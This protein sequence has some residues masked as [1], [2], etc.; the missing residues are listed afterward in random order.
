M[1][2]KEVDKILKKYEKKLAD[3][4]GEGYIEDFENDVVNKEYELFRS[5]ILEQKITNYER[6]C[7]TAEGFLKVKPSDKDYEKIRKSIDAAHLNVTPESAASLGAM[8]GILLIILG[9]VVGAL[10][11]VFGN[12][13]LFLPIVLI[14]AGAIVIKPLSNM[15][16]YLA[17]KWRLEA[18][19]QMVLCVL[20]V[21]MYMR[22]TSNLEHAIRFAAQHV[23]PPLSLDL[24]KVFWDIETERF[25]SIKESLD[26]YLESWRDHNLEFVQSFNLIEGSLYEPNN[27]RRISLLE[28]ALE[29]MLEG[30]YNKMLHYAH[31]LKGPITLLYMLG[32]ILPILGLVIFPLIGSFMGGLV[33]WYHLAMLYNLFL[34]LILIFLGS[35]LLAKRPTGYGESEILRSHP[36][37]KIYEQWM[38]NDK[39]VP[40]SPKVASIFVAIIIGIFGLLPLLVPIISPGYDFEVPGLGKMFD[41]KDFGGGPYGV[42]ALLLGMLTPLGIAA[43]VSMYYGIK[44]KRLIKV[45]KKVDNLEDEF[46][47]AIF[48]L[49]NRIA[50]GI[51]SEMAFGDVAKAM[52]GTPTGNFFSTV[53][54]NIRK[55][56]YGMKKAVFDN[57]VGAILLFPSNL[58]QTTMK[59]LIETARK[60]PKVASSS[61]ITISEY[62][63]RIKR[64]NERLRDLLADVLSS[65]SSQ[66]NFL[67]PL[68]AGIV[69][70][71]GSMVT[72]IIN[73]LSI[74]F[75]SVGET[76][77]GGLGNMGAITNILNIK[78][79][80]PGYY[81]QLVVGI[82]VVQITIILTIL[83]TS[84][85]RGVD[86]TTSHHRISKNLFRS[87]LMYFIVSLVGVL[88]FNFLANAV[89]FAPAGA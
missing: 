68:I 65:M 67:T 22:H 17:N 69:V 29:V 34:P 82:Y 32:V 54:R 85:E 10:S 3:Q 42:G 88:L 37:F 30:T 80:I 48:Q 19:N 58:I 76:G 72:T 43:G 1:V 45:K 75:E 13:M 74:A 44:T 36:E 15:P 73:K 28:K 21:V 2:K 9:L 51:P 7:A 26:N 5:E 53:D 78:D 47:G 87:V 16:V 6:W 33:K 64:V 71:V 18:S 56:G 79:V 61:L 20:Y 25:F 52:S 84:I 39:V 59:V 24:K 23:G 4:Y 38:V 50:D 31:N 46:S 35:N 11:F 49:G 86:K 14:F 41:F 89:S 40:I 83:S 27:Q 63:D 81:F 55:L 66:I 12:L 57:R 8:A 70:G 62:V 77:Y 60:G